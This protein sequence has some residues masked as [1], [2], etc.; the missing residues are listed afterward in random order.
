MKLPKITPW[1]F[2]VFASVVFAVS[3]LFFHL[4]TSV[5]PIPSWVGRTH[6]PI[7]LLRHWP[8]GSLPMLILLT[9][10]AMRWGWAKGSVF[11]ESKAIQYP[12]RPDL[13]NEQFWL[14][15]HSDE[16]RIARE[17]QNRGTTK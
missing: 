8:L 14:W 17:R 10:S 1:R 11:P 9:A 16:G 12:L 15:A 3:T 7:W 13:N 4:Y 5:A 6:L 2:L